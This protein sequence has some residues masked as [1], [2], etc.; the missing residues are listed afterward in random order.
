MDGTTAVDVALQRVRALIADG[1]LR[2][3][4]RLPSEGVLSEQ[5]GV[6]RGSIREAI[7]MLAALGVVDTRHGSG[8]FV[9]ELRAADV[10]ESLSLTVGLLPLESVLELYELRRV[11]ESHAASLAAARAAPG[12]LTALAQ[13]LDDLERAGNDE[14][15]SQLDHEFHMRIARVGGNDALGALVSVLRS[16]SR[17]YKLFTSDSADEIKRLSDAGHRAILRG[18][19]AQDPVAAAAAAA[20]HVTQTEV[21]LRKLRPAAQPE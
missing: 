4:D 12:D 15:Q 13:T 3:G 2:T 11:L 21:W 16:R 7:R 1:T 5:L 19:E 8:S 14:R 20:A 10:I 9:A 17:A 18:I 6:S